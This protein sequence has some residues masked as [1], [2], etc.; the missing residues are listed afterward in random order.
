MTILDRYIIKKI[1]ATF[2]Y[3][4]LILVAII[5]VI[6]VTEKIDKFVVNNLSTARILG[7]Y[8]DFIP[9]IAGLISPI[10]VFITI[11]YVTSRMAAHTEII[12]ILSS[13]VSFRRFLVPYF[14]AAFIIAGLSFYLNGW[15]IP[16]SNRERIEFEMQYFKKNNLT[17]RSNIHMQIEPNVYLFIQ[18]FSSQTRVG[19]QFTLERFDS[20]RLVEKLTAENIRWD[21]TKNKWTL[22]Y[23]KHKPIDSI[24]RIRPS[25]TTI[26]LASRGDTMDT[27]LAV[28]PKDFEA[29]DRGYDGM[30]IRELTE[31][32][33]K[34]RFRGSTG[35]EVYE[36][37]KQ[38]RYA[39]PF[40]IFVL[41]FMGA[42]VSSRKSRGGT[43]FQIALGFLLSFIFILFFTMTRTFAETGS[44]PPFLAAWLPNGV[45]ILISLGMYKYVPR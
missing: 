28:T 2:F 5:T 33:E 14:V 40:T 34:M 36:T 27:T 29:T 42:L 25:G 8:G 4:V 19:H 37:E 35:V 22:R 38:I 12:A 41:V 9:W 16:K 44:L 3:V 20:N 17:S 39:I 21:T 23:W 32:I 31:Q 26:Q 18:N 30:T 10:T 11:V 1:L 7:Y 15:V 43:G 13:G 24:F 45:F 6:D